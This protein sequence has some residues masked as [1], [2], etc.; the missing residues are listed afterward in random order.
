MIKQLTDFY[1]RYCPSFSERFAKDGIKFLFSKFVKDEFSNIALIENLENINHAQK[2]FDLRNLPRVLYSF[3][4]P[5]S[6]YEILYR[7]N[8]LYYENITLL[9]NK[10]SKF[11]SKDISLV[12]INT[13]TLVNDYMIINDKCYSEQS[14]DNPYSNL[15][16]FGYSKCV[17]YSQKHIKDAT[18]LIYIIRYKNTNVGCIVL[19]M[20][21]DLCYISGLAILKQYRKTKVFT[22]LI[23]IL[24]IL[25]KHNI[26]N[27]FCVTEHGEYPEKL[28]LK[29]GFKSAGIAYGFKTK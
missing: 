21:D 26:Q 16:N 28:Y 19:T 27:V 23:N 25:I 14:Y 20:K 17:F 7:D 11:K 3:K 6:N 2:E 1:Y 8:F 13:P 4:T 24:E 12:E 9:Y 5:N 22:A 29:L 18:T 15:D 10:F